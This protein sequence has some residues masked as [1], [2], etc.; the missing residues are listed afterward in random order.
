MVNISV[1]SI[2]SIVIDH[3]SF[4]PRHDQEKLP[5]DLLLTNTVH[6]AQARE[7][8][9]SNLLDVVIVDA[10]LHQGGG[11]VLGH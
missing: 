6:A 8:P 5:L 7:S 1:A 3:T 9:S 11:K 2:S 4:C 10:E